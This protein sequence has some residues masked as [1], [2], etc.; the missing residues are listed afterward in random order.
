MMTYQEAAA[1]PS[2]EKISLI[3]CEGVK[4]SKLF[5]L[6]SDT[7]Y[8]KNVEYF[9]SG[10]KKNG[11]K[12]SLANSINPG[13]NEYFYDS[14]TKT[15]YVNVG[16]DPK[17]TN[18][19]IVYKFFFSNV[20][21]ILKSEITFGE[22]VEFLP[23]VREIS[24][25]GQ[26]LDDENSGIVL[27]SQGSVD[28]I[29]NEGFF[30]PIIDTIIFENQSITFYSAFNNIPN[31]EIRKI[32]DG[33]IESK[34]F[35]PER[36]RFSVKDFVFKLRNFVNLGLFSELD[37]NVLE[38]IIGTPK[39]RIYGQV[40]QARCIPLD[41]VL[42]GYPLTGTVSFSVDSDIMTGTGTQFLKELNQNDDII[43]IFNN[44]EFTLTV[45]L[46][47]ND[48]S[49]RLS[50]AVEETITNIQVIVD[51]EHP[52]R[53]KNRRWHIA[54]HKLR[55]TEAT[56]LDVINGRTFK[57]DDNSEFK[58][59]DVI[60]VNGQSTQVTRVS[61]DQI[62]LEQTIFPI[63]TIGDKITRF[64]VTR[65]MF[66]ER[67]FVPFRDFSL[68]NTNE[69][70]I[71]LSPL[72]EFNIAREVVTDHNMAF[73][74]SKPYEAS[75]SANADLRTIIKP[76]DFVRPVEQSTD[77]W[78]EV[79]HVGPQIIYLKTP[80]NNPSGNVNSKVRI[81]KVNTV[82]DDS[83]ILVDCYGKESNNQWIKTASD[84]V[85]DLVINDAEFTAIDE[86]SFSQANSDCPYIMSLVFPDVGG[87]TPLVRDIITRI[88]ESVFGSLYGNSSQ[89]IAY[90]I[91]NARRPQNLSQ[92]QDDDIIDW[93]VKTNQKIASDIKVNYLPA[94]DRVTGEDGF[95][96]VT[97]QNNFVTNNSGIK[98]TIEK[99][100][101]LFNQSDAET[102]AQRFAFYNSLSQSILS[103]KAKA[104]FFTFSV[105]DR[106]YVNL[107]RMYSRYGGSNNLKIG[108][109]SGISKGPYN[110][111]V[112]MNDLGNIFNRC[113]VI[114]P[115]TTNA[116]NEASD[117]EKIKYGFILD[118]NTLIPGNDESDLGSGLIG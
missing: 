84:C 64:P 112:E 20:P 59:G 46:V 96:V 107:D 88:N 38:S 111:E 78:Y 29:N 93:S 73:T 104:N 85:R 60:R 62:I 55:Q 23:L 6:V 35:N 99:T 100:C 95:S 117:D 106:I 72:A 14:S 109:I 76:G 22:D 65:L 57:V 86:D 98:N 39:R 3:I 17:F 108:V 48:T 101:Y 51:S 8:R 114:C 32:F 58:S 18:L 45:D 1:L 16:E 19:S 52:Y 82:F 41:C 61:V 56:I 7:V 24:S 28:F 83:L 94:V 26:Q 70:I 12:L 81:K 11:T 21:I 31:N 13:L 43:F 75:S 90:S 77:S 67:D 97:Y 68:V 47:I 40:K 2:S 115:V 34:E 103:I 15:V 37:G 102:I 79:H 113:P 80:F 118:T 27:E 9:V 69:S 71:E 36:V 5:D 66:G 105:N 44:E 74:L 10:I 89:E 30:D 110:S 42:D 92:I 49:A 33:V 63:P 25:I 54:G 116:Y 50:R 91:V 53:F 87:E 4:P